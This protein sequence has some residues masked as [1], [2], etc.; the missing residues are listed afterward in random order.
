MTNEA[1]KNAY[2]KLNPQQKTAVDTIEGPVMVIAGPGT[3][4]TQIL[5]L[6]IAN[7]LRTTDMEPSSVLALTFTESG[8]ASMRRRLMDLIGGPAYSVAI[9]TFHGFCNDVIKDYPEEFPRIIGSENITDVDQIRILE[10]AIETIPLAELRPFGDTLHYLGAILMAINELKREGVSADRFTQE[11]DKERERFEHIEDLY[12]DKGA[13]KGKM[14]GHYQKLDK[15]IR[16]NAELA[17]VYAYYQKRLT[18]D[19]KYDYSDM[20]ME[21][22]EVLTTNKNLLLMLQEQYQY[23]LVDEHQDTNNA[24]NKIIE[25]LCNFHPNP[26]LFVVGDEKQAIYRFQGA[27]LENFLYFKNLYPE[28]VLI[29]LEENY[30]STQTILD[31]AHNVIPGKKELKANVAHTEAPIRIFNCADEQVE[32]YLIAKDI[33]NHIAAGVAADEI[34]VLYRNNRDMD[35]IADMLQKMQIPFTVSSD[36]DILEDED[37]RKLLMLLRAV[38]EFGSQES[39]IEAMHVDFLGIDPL[40]LY[41]VM[42]YANRSKVSVYEVARSLDVLQT[43]DLKLEK[44][45]IINAWY[46]KIAQWSVV[47]RNKGLAELFEIVMRESG[48][49]GHILASENPVE[50]IEVVGGLFEEIK[51][52]IE[53]HRE[54]GLADFFAYIETL[55]THNI[56]IKKSIAGHGSGKVRLM[57]AHKSKGLE[58]EYVYII[59]AFDGHWGNKRKKTGFELPKRLFSL[60]GSDFTEEED[61]NADERRLFYVA[62]TR[63]KKEIVITYAA[64]NSNGRAQLP[65]QFIGELREDL[66]TQADAAPYEAELGAQKEL[67]FAP[68]MLSGV[69]IKDK[70]YIRE[71]FLRNGFSVTA[72]NNYLECPWKYFYTNLLRIPKAPSKHQ[73]YGIAIHS[74][75]KDFFDTIKEREVDKQFLLDKFTYYL[76]R[77]PLVK[78]EYEESLAKGLKALGGYYD[79][80]KGA[81]R[82]NALTEFAVNGIMLTPEIRLTGKIDKIEFIGAGNEVN[83]V[84]YKTGKPKSR[85]DIEGNTQASEGNIKRQ[86][87]F[88]KLLLDRHEDGKYRMLSGDIDFIEPNERGVYRKEMFEIVPE[89]LTALEEEIKRVGQEILDGIF[90]EKRCDDAECEYCALRDMMQ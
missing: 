32:R 60:A 5:T 9:N 56:R 19:K 24:Q 10:D 70:E 50:K 29:V 21:V 41:K 11:V 87:I 85:N 88:Y 20:I 42:D 30:R 63:A 13:H 14:K 72:L 1:F 12:H 38:N 53:A 68:R 76:T 8:V 82:I 22:L 55:K 64:I 45:Q 62:L 31:S 90:W 18:D 34:A 74:A 66:L 75:L 7:I 59:N 81:W 47:S 17:L 43:P 3:G 77:Q 28:A 2:A 89:E 52:L 73:M 86:L 84:D 49:L 78:S 6:R 44:P 15:S 16:K 54:Y 48:F 58:F 40:D 35:P 67:L 51:K 65:S 39:F 33:A 25:L 27:S 37:I 36:Q 57:T 69:D 23:I 4:K 26:N 46:G 71:L 83:V 79:T 61:E 80:Y